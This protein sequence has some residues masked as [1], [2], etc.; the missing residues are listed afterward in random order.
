MD[1]KVVKDCEGNLQEEKQHKYKGIACP[2]YYIQ[3]NGKEEWQVVHDMVTQFGDQLYQHGLFLLVY[4]WLDDMHD[5]LVE[6]CIGWQ[7]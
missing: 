7:G 1:L 3:S 2:Y 6:S 4:D 5:D